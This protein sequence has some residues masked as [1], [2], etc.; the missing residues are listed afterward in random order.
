MLGTMSLYEAQSHQVISSSVS[1][2]RTKELRKRGTK[3]SGDPQFPSLVSGHGKEQKP[4][5]RHLNLK[6]VEYL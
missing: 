3:L 4:P 1:C 2:S 5:D 6:E